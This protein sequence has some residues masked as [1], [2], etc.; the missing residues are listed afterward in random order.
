M[1]LAPW[2]IECTPCNYS[3]P[4]GGSGQSGADEAGDFFPVLLLGV[5][6]WGAPL[7]VLHVKRVTPLN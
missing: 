5:G 4:N 3:L 1:G 6:E 2:P 7:I